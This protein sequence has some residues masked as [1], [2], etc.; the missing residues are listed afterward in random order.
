[1]TPENILK[2]LLF[3]LMISFIIETAY[4]ISIG[5]II[6]GGKLYSFDG[7]WYVLKD[8]SIWSCP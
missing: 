7:C 4:I 6:Y 3:L 5:G 8:S 1:M 2:F